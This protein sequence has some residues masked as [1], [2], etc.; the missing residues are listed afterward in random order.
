[1]AE[2][3]KDEKNLKPFPE[4]LRSWLED[5]FKEG[6]VSRLVM[7]APG[8]LTINPMT[9]GVKGTGANAVWE[10]PDEA[11]LW[12]GDPFC[13]HRERQ[14]EDPPGIYILPKPELSAPGGVSCWK[15]GDDPSCHCGVF[16]NAAVYSPRKAKKDEGED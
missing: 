8:D 6:N 14:N 2:T 13:G 11:P 5:C 16:L 10:G 7:T 1:M 3:K 15:V 9:G 4:D 12:A